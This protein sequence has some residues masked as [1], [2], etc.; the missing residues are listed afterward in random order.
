MLNL[1]IFLTATFIRSI[2]WVTLVVGRSRVYEHRGFTRGFMGMRRRC[3][4][5]D[6]ELI[7]FVYLF[8]LSAWTFLAAFARLFFTG[9]PE[10][11]LTFEGGSDNALNCSLGLFSQRWRL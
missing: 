2:T 5:S 1:I 4:C 7:D 6:N 10:F 8:S 11:A 3:S 9:T